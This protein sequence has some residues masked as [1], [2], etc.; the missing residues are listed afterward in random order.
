M[1]ELITQIFK[2]FTVNGVSIPVLF[3]QYQG[4]GE[5]YII[6]NKE[7]MGNSISA[8]DNLENYIEYYNFTIYSRGNY[9]PIVA[10]VKE[11]LLENDFF[12]EPYQ[13]VGDLFD[14]ETKYYFTTLNFSYLRS[15]QN[16]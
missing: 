10:A 5:P 4:H 11:K 12:W 14:F 1:N 9:Q 15:A 7:N 6:W 13:S 8:D 2:N 3:L 16:G